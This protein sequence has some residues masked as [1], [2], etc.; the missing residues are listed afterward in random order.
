MSTVTAG[1]VVAGRTTAGTTTAGTTT[2]STTTAGTT[3]AGTT[4]AGTTT[5]GTTT[6]GRPKVSDAAVLYGAALRRAATGRPAGLTLHDDTGQPHRLDAADWY[7]DELPGDRGMLDRID[8]PALDVGCGP[9][10]LTAALLQRGQVA[11]GVDVSLTAV[12]LAR[13][14]GAVALR[15]DVFGSLPGEGRWRHVLLADGNIGIGGDP[16]RLLHR[17]AGLLGPDGRMHA[18]LAAPGTRGWAG[19]AYLRH[20]DGR[21]SAPFRWAAV[22]VPEISTLAAAAGLRVTD[23]WTEAGRWFATLAHS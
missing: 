19:P 11:L 3:T 16:A 18:E 23:T 15:R 5:A 6:A 17:C 10:R 13:A 9:G 8:G 2:A 12:R 1:P 4:T 20:D 7:R 14:R 21:V 22:A